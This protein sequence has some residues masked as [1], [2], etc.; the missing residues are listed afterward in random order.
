[1]TDFT[2]NGKTYNDL[3]YSPSN[4]YGMGLGGFR[5]N[6]APAMNDALT[7]FSSKVAAC[8]ASATSASASAA[9]AVNAPGTSATSTTSLAIGLGSQAFTLAQTGKAF[10]LGQ[11]VVIASTAAPDTNWMAGPI[12][13]FNSGTG[14]I[15][16]TSKVFGGSGT[17]TSW[18]IS[19]TAPVG[20]ANPYFKVSDQK[21]SGTNGGSSV[22]TD[23]TQIRPFN[24]VDAN[25][26]SGASL[27]SNVITL[28]AGT[29]RYKIRSSFFIVSAK[30]FLYNSTDASYVGVGSNAI[31][32]NSGSNADSFISGV[33]TIASAKNFT[34][35][36]Y[37]SGAQT[38]GLGGAINSGQ[39]E[40]Y[41]EAEFEKVA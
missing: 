13:S 8:A 32:W 10:S 39:V 20:M 25:T 16:V 6:W 37:A 23:I 31:P 29:Y 7:D 3:D 5:Y 36:Y 38:G 41:S 4:L 21:S 30:V 22:A 15:T 14:A 34:L 11:W 9:T 12:A 1:M 27:A 35:R 18:T 19:V 2:V 33:M 28:P 24:T 17:F 40:I 26:M